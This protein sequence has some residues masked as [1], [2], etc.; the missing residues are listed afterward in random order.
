MTVNVALEFVVQ[1]LASTRLER[2]FV[3]P[4]AKVNSGRVPPPL[5]TVGT[6]ATPVIATLFVIVGNGSPSVMTLVTE[7]F[8]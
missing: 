3:V 7:I 6:V 8:I 4:A 5:M 1:P 2:L